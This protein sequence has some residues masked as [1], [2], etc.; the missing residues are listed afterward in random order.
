MRAME[1]AQ[2]VEALA[3]KPENQSTILRTHMMDQTAP[4]SCPLAS[5]CTVI[6][7]YTGV[8]ARTYTHTLTSTC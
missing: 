7:R 6:R 8:R 1:M 4:T 2:E 5:I 3:L